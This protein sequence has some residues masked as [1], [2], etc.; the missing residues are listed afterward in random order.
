MKNC[1]LIPRASE[2]ERELHVRADRAEPTT[3][4]VPPSPPRAYLGHTLVQVLL[5]ALFFFVAPQFQLHGHTVLVALSKGHAPVFAFVGS[6]RTVAPVTGT[7]CS[8]RGARYSHVGR[9]CGRLR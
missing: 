4:T 3:L 8:V 9:G 5:E 7:R 2:S 6:S 1:G